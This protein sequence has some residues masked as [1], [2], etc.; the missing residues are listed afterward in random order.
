MTQFRSLSRTRLIVVVLALLLVLALAAAASAGGGQSRWSQRHGGPTPLPPA[1]GN[2]HYVVSLATPGSVGPGCLGPDVTY[3]RGDALFYEPHTGPGNPACW[4]PWFDG[5]NSGLG[6][7]VDINALHD[8]CGPTDPVCDIYL[9]FKANTV[10]PDVGTVRPHDVVR[11]S[12]NGASLDT[13][14]NWI[15]VFDGSDVGLTTAGEKI[16]ALFISAQSPGPYPPPGQQIPRPDCYE[17]LLVSTSGAYT[18]PDEW[19]NDFSGGGEDVLGFCASGLGWYTYGYWFLYHDGSANG[20]PSNALIGLNHEDLNQAFNRFDFMTNGPFSVDTADGSHSEVFRFLPNT[21]EYI[22]PT[23]SFPDST[24]V[25][26]KIDSF[27]V[28]YD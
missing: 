4:L 21:D 2:D 9:S 23:F 24:D 7:N 20:M 19:G 14:E 22:G 13:Y 16:D 17:L 3:S 8:V 10:V 28:Y 5:S 1:T 25:T 6:S 11:G 26:D 15:L 12:W 18:V 27:T